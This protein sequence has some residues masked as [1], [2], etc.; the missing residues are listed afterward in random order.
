VFCYSNANIRKGEE[1]EE[2]FRFIAFWRR[3]Y[4]SLPRHLV[5]DSKLT[6]YDGLDRLD[7]A[8]I[9]V[10]T[11]APALAKPARRDRWPVAIG[12]AH[13]H[14]GHLQPQASNPA[15][16]RTDGASALAR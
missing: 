6:T 14:P 5:F 15:L 8:G 16:L 13:R 4:G 3:Q 9:I 10:I 12:L 7:A 2:V 11:L 1:A